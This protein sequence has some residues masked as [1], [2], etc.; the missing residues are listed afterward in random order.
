M[1]S[2]PEMRLSRDDHLFIHG[3]QSINER[4]SAMLNGE[5]CQRKLI[6]CIQVWILRAGLTWRLSW[7]ALQFLHMSLAAWKEFR[8]AAECH[9]NVS[10]LIISGEWETAFDALVNHSHS[11]S[12]C[13][14]CR[15]LLTMR[16]KISQV[17][18]SFMLSQIFSVLNSTCWV[19]VRIFMLWQTANPI[20]AFRVISSLCFAA[21]WGMLSSWEK[22]LF[23][24]IYSRSRA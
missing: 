8:N 17:F 7:D 15:M 21:S 24:R 5:E 3:F 13:V 19:I 10:S 4:Q 2:S 23:P 20:V 22:H 18:H 16:V 11:S 9:W 14:G 6:K 12:C 1:N